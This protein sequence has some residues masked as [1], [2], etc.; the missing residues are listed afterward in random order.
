MWSCHSTRQSWHS[1]F[2]HDTVLTPCTASQVSGLSHFHCPWRCPWVCRH[3]YDSTSPPSAL[4]IVASTSAHRVHLAEPHPFLL[5]SRDP[6]IPEVK[7]N[8]LQGMCPRAT[9]SPVPRCVPAG[10]GSGHFAP[11]PSISMPLRLARAASALHLGNIISTLTCRRRCRLRAVPP[12]GVVR[13]PFM[14][15]RQ[16]TFPGVIFIA[17]SIRYVFG[18]WH[19]SFRVTRHYLIGVSP[20][21]KCQICGTL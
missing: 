15:S 13:C 17:F 19:P 11:C 1:A 2:R 14:S 3:Y 21:P 16:L 18:S 6:P 12:L 4:P 5:P 9:N 20:S 10:R 8:R 7:Q